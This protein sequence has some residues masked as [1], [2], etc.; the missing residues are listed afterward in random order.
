MA[1]ANPVPKVTNAQPG[2]AER[3]LEVAKSQIGVI[4][5]PKDNETDY[6][7][8]TGHDLQAWCGS[9]MMWIADKSGVKIPDCVYTPN[10]ANAFKKMGAWADAASAHPEPGDLAF[11][12]FVPAAT[13]SSPIQHIGVVVK[14]NGDGTVTTYEGNTS[15]DARPHGSQNNGGEFAL[16]VRGYKI[17]N[18]RHIWA[19]IVG[20]GR[21]VYAGAVA[22]HPATPVAK[23]LPAFPGRIAP[24]DKNANVK[25][26]QQAL[27][28][29]ADGEYGP[30]T[31][32][33]VIA[34]QDGHHTLDS[35]GIIGPAT[36]AEMMKLI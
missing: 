25:L 9:S 21:P 22:S 5:G 2:T 14:D 27:G 34:F 26:V 18:K 32:K 19:S 28:L 35:N 17:D 6:G 29:D 7:K 4:E 16:K 13:P 11:F 33:A 31:K 30:A 8:F 15:S 24:G 1:K 20:F 10:G 36:W 23:V 12:S 3:F